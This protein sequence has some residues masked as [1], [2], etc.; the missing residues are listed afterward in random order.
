[1][2]DRRSFTLIELLVVVAIIA[3]LAALLLPALGRAKENGKRAVCASNLHQFGLALNMYADDNSGSLPLSTVSLG[4]GSM[5]LL[6]PR[7]IASPVGYWC[8]STTFTRPP[9]TDLVTAGDGFAEGEI[10]LGW[11]VTSPRVSYETAGVDANGLT[12]MIDYGPTPS[13]MKLSDLV[14]QRRSMM[15][16]LVGANNYYLGGD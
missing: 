15:W 12:G 13:G 1:M 4:A 8:P 9:T 11:P 10:T 2:Y 6:Y 3:I 16:D 5:A 14:S 7:Y